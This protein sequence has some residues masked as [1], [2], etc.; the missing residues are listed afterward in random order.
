M[1]VIT[2]P[3]EVAALCKRLARA[4]Y[5]TVDTDFMRERTYWSQLCLIQLAGPDEAAAIDPLAPGMDLSPLFALLQNEKVL[6]VFHAARQDLEIFHH[7][8]GAVPHPV[9]DTQVAAMVCGFGDQVS[10]EILARKLAGASIDK[11]SR[12]TDWARRPLTDKQV[13]YAL[14]DV[15]HL[16]KAYEKIRAMLDKNGRAAWIEEEMAVLTSPSTYQ[17][18]AGDAWQ[19]IKIKGHKPRI[20]AVLRELAAWR[21]ETAQ[22]RDVSRQR[23]VKDDAIAQI[24]IQQP[25]S[26]EDLERVRL[27]PHGFS[28]SEDGKAIVEAVKRGLA[29]PKEDLPRVDHGSGKPENQAPAALIDLLKVLVRA[30]CEAEGIAPRLVANMAE[31]E[32]FASD[33]DDPDNPLRHGW[34]YDLFGK[35][36]ERLKRGELALAPVGDGLKL[37]EIA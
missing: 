6:K 33:D 5:I 13:D 4:E 37:I 27:V 22:K 28:R 23:V 25:A 17:T 14:A 8:T 7:L 10:Y 12:F 3:G 30:R 32:R 9:F 18:E 2:D 29:V 16:R 11:D 21:E 35:D 1:S 24:A 36:A 31:V 26:A 19:R 20:M 15:T 34:R